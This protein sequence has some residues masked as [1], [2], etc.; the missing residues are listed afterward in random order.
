[1]IDA[2][3]PEP[4]ARARFF[5]VDRDGL[6]VQ[7]MPGLLEFQQP[8]AQATAAVAGWRR[9][10]PDRIGLF[11]VVAN[12]KP[13]VLIGVSGQHGIFDERIV[14]MMAANV[15]R[16]VIFPLSNPVSRSEAT[17][18]DLETWSEGRAVI[19][20]GS[21]FPP[22]MRHGKHVTVDQ[23]NNAYVFPGVGLG[24][25]AV[26][27]RRVSDNMFKAAAAALA[28][29]SPARLDP[30]A[31]LLP[32]VADLRSVAVAVAQAVAKAARDDGL[33]EPL[34]DESIARRIAGKMWEPTYR[35]YRLRQRG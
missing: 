25:L 23:T 28:D 10:Q 13:T 27:A 35:P 9:E 6:L 24:V 5:A 22:I 2:G 19:G 33:C 1:M 21:P 4:E 20:A 26:G 30:A 29:V 32:A 34:D 16:P 7:G 17:P 18:Q 12:A 15:A 31:N 11:D 3:V 14:R 8:F